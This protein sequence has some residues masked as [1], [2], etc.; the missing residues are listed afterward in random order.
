MS[1]ETVFLYK[2]LKYGRLSNVGE[3][4]LKKDHWDVSALKRFFN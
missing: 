3:S 4:S 2:L 1:N